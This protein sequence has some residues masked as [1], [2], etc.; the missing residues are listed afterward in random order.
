MKDEKS[1]YIEPKNTKNIYFL[2]R[3]VLNHWTRRNKKSIALENI[4]ILFA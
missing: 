1:S 4:S 3:K 2:I